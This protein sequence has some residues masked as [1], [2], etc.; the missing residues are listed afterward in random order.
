MEVH[1]RTLRYPFLVTIVLLVLGI[2]VSSLLW[3]LPRLTAEEKPA[4][5]TRPLIETNAF[6]TAP[7]TG[8][9][10]LPVIDITFRDESTT[11]DWHWKLTCEPT[12]EVY[13][14]QRY[15][16]QAV[17]LTLV[18]DPTISLGVAYPDMGAPEAVALASCEG[19]D[20]S[21]TCRV[22]VGYGTAGPPL[23]LVATVAPVYA[24]QEAVRAKDRQ[25]WDAQPAWDWSAFTP[26]IQP[27][28]A[29]WQS[30]CVTLSPA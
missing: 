28:E 29:G 1:I 14:G 6:P 5:G 24:I 2:G 16:L 7:P 25:T 17:S 3:Q 27:T 30:Q 20:G 23:D 9:S 10:T 18:D 11:W 19:A 4:T 12:L 21:L 8:R 26:L 13:L 22:A 15:P